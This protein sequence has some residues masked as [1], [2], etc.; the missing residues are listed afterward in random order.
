VNDSLSNTRGG[1]GSGGLVR[2]TIVTG[3]YSF[4]SADVAAFNATRIVSGSSSK[5][6]EW[7]NAAGLKTSDNVYNGALIGSFTVPA[8]VTAIDIGVIGGGGGGAIGPCINAGG[9]G[10]GA[11]YFQRYAV[12]A[13]TAY[14]IK[15]GAGGQGGLQGA[16]RGSITPDSPPY[17]VSEAPWRGGKTAFCDSSGVELIYATGGN[18][19]TDSCAGVTNADSA[20]SGTADSPGANQPVPP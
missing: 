17:G 2:I 16:S 3:S 5:S 12:S 7:D 14:Q 19:R 6:I 20:S 15:V 11:A 13:S 1:R 9:G 10:G 18:T 4:T 8:G